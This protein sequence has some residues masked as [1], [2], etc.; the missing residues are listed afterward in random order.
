MLSSFIGAI[1]AFCCRRARWVAFATIVLGI[2]AGIYAT[3]NFAMNSNSETLIS[4]KVPWRVRQ[5]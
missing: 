4:P 5:A 3:H 2:A 1:V